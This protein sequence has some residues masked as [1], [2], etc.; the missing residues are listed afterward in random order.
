MKHRL[1]QAS[2]VLTGSSSGIGRAAALRFA[3]RGA[4]LV[5]AARSQPNLD[6][7]AETCRRCGVDVEV[8]PTD[9]TDEQA[10]QEL[11]RRALDHFGRIDVWVNN[12]A[13]TAFG[14]FDA[15]PPE[16]FRRVIETNLF[17]Y[18]HGARAV[19]PVF[20]RQGSGV[21]INVASMVG[22]VG[23]PLASAYV[24]SKFAVVGLSESLRQ[25]LRD[26]DIDVCTIL[27]ASIDT[28][29]FQ[30]GANYTGREPQPIPPVYTAAK[31]ASAIVR[32]A[33][34]PRRE[35]YVGNA[36]RIAGFLRSIAPATAERV[37]AHNV[38]KRHFQ[39]RVAPS[40]TGNL[41]HPRADLNAVDGGWRSDHSFLQT[42]AM[43]GMVAAP[44]LIGWLAARRN[45]A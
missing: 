18:V 34:R 13:V 15:M 11:C 2:V 4:N 33:E 20:R 6:E 42:I 7:V 26:T 43:A 24:A 27:P 21:L 19:I 23:Q 40:H 39:D 3:E 1:N 9:V 35:T 38:E 10:V 32:T 41:F 14:Q 36:G 16:V 12:A 28:P 37:I 25:E 22:K 30:H 5:L 17:G 31:V 44:V 29:L 45:G 8:V